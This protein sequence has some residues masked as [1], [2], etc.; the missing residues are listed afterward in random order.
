[1]C[2]VRERLAGIGRKTSSRDPGKAM[3]KFDITDLL[4][5]LCI[6]ATLNSGATVVSVLLAVWLIG[7]RHPVR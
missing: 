7:R 3:D 6:G 1:M 2:P 5:A 4:V